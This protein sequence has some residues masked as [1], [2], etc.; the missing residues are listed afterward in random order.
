MIGL[1]IALT[2]HFLGVGAYWGSVYLKGEE[3]TSSSSGIVTIPYD[4]IEL[5]RSVWQITVPTGSSSGIK[6]KVGTPVPVPEWK[7]DPEVTIPKQTEPPPSSALPDVKP[8]DGENVVYK[9]DDAEP[10]DVFVAWEKPPEVVRQVQ[11]AYPELAVRA[12]LEGT[13]VV[14]IWVDREGRAKKALVQKSDAEIFNQA[15]TE[16]AMQWVFTPAMMKHGPVSVWISVPFRF[17]LQAR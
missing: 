4:R 10:P 13:V 7:A 2:L 5:P 15:A 8:G 11:A 6:I 16:A 17:K 14:K 3:K 9:S 12:G 1:V